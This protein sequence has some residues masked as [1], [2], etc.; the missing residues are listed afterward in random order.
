MFHFRKGRGAVNLGWA[1]NMLVSFPHT[2]T[3]TQICDTT[4]VVVDRREV[5]YVLMQR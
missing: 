3:D 5:M 1:A 2:P 4:A